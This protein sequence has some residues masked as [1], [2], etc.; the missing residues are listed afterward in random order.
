MTENENLELLYRGY[1]SIYAIIE[2]VHFNKNKKEYHNIY[3][4]TRKDK[5]YVM[6][7]DG[8]DWILQDKNVTIKDLK[9]NIVYHIDK[10]F[11]EYRDTE[12]LPNNKKKS[13]SGFLQ[14]IE[15]ENDYNIEVSNNIELLLYN[16]RNIVLNTKK[17]NKA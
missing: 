14:K 16:K 8:N 2:H 13:I 5:K 10:K 11:K 9:D 7:Y 17:M 15:T 6:I 3:M 4:P 12:K 1:Q